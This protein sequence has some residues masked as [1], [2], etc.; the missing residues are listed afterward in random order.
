MKL[1]NN[2]GVKKHD[3]PILSQLDVD[4]FLKKSIIHY[5]P[6][7]ST[8]KSVQ[9]AITSNNVARQDDIEYFVAQI[10]SDNLM[11]QLDADH[12]VED[13]ELSAPTQMMSFMTQKGL[14]R[15]LTTDL[16]NAL[17]RQI[18]AASKDLKYGTPSK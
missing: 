9:L 1:L 4:Q 7:E 17:A 8:H 10:P 3:G 16:Y 2:V 15:N 6:T 5:F 14:V 13:A 18:N 11:T 12:E